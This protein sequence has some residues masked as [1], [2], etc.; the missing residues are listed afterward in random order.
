MTR[1]VEHKQWMYWASVLSNGGQTYIGSP[2]GT[3]YNLYTDPFPYTVP[4]DRWLVLTS[5]SFQSKYG[6]LGRS[7]YAVIYQIMTLPDVSPSWIACHPKQGVILPPGGSFN[8]CFI[9]NEFFNEFGAITNEPQ[10]MTFCAIGYE[11]DHQ[12]G[13]TRHNCLDGVVF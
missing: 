7:S 4:A 11:V 12:E 9:N 8:G 2:Q 10:N 1:V 3:P 5:L 6:G 13:M